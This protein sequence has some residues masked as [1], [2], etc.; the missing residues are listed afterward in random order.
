MQKNHNESN[1]E[2]LN[3]DRIN[4][5]ARLT[6]SY[7]AK[8]KIGQLNQMLVMSSFSFQYFVHHGILAFI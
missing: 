4:I 6:Y 1:I 5:N 7:E 2:I 3:K 8:K